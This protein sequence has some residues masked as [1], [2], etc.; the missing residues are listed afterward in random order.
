S[1][2][3][4][5]LVAIVHYDDAVRAGRIGVAG[6]ADEGGRA[7]QLRL[8][9]VGRR[10]EDVDRLVR[11]VCEEVGLTGSLDEADVEARQRLAA[12]REVDE[13]DLVIRGRGVVG[14]RWSS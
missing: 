9:C 14:E 10:V 1:V 12:H 2:A 8:K 6:V 7:G 3:D 13:S 11:T 4:P 5:E